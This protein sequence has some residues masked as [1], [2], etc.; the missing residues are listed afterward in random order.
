MRN[1]FLPV[2]GFCLLAVPTLAQDKDKTPPKDKA[3]AAK[4]VDFA[5]QIWPIL[6]KSCVECHAAAHTGADGKMKKPKGGVVLDHKDG[7]LAGKKGKPLFVAK[8][9]DESMIY[10]SITLPAD[11][12]DRM[13]PAK[14]GDPLPKDQQ[15]LIKKW[16]EDGGEFGTWTGKKAEEKPKEGEKG[17]EKPATP[18]AD[19][20]KGKTASVDPIPELQKGMKPLAANVLEAFA[21]GPFA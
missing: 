5:T 6:E 11:D 19:K 21:S 7:I 16:I 20:P 14:K 17:K 4:G 13:P 12:E 8:K 15:E 1:P 2:L 18:P 9:P 3:P 10:Q